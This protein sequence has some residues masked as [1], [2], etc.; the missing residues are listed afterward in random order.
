MPGCSSSS[1]SGR[2]DC[3]ASGQASVP[4]ALRRNLLI[5]LAGCVALA[6]LTSWVNAGSYGVRL[7]TMAAI[8][9]LLALGYQ[10]VF[11][12]LGAFSL[13]QG[14]FF[15][16]G[17][18]ATALLATRLGLDAAIT[19]PLS[20]AIAVG[21]A[22]I[23]A[24]PVLRLESHYFALATLGLA[25]LA[26]LVAVNAESL[27]GGGNGLPGVPGLALLGWDVPRG[28][29][30]MTA[31]WMLVALAAAI[32]WRGTSGRSRHVLM[33]VRDDPIAAESL[34]IDIG[35]LRFAAF[36]FA[37]GCAG[38]AGALQAHLLGIV[39]P[40]VLEFP[41]MVACLS[42][43][44][45]GGRGSIAGAV[46][47]A[48][49]LVH[50]PELLRGVGPW[51]LAV[52]GAALLAM[53]VFAPEG[54]VGLL[55]RP[56]KPGL[57]ESAE[58]ETPLPARGED[59][60]AKPSGTILRLRGVRKKFGGVAALA[61]IDLEIRAGELVGIIGPN[62]SGKTTLVNVIAGLYRPDGGRVEFRGKAIQDEPAWR[63]ARAGIGRGFQA[64]RLLDHLTVEDNVAI[65]AIAAG[66]GRPIAAARLVRRLGL[67]SV[68]RS[69]LGMLPGGARR[70][71][72]IARAMMGRPSL[73]LL[74]EPAAG[75]TPAEQEELRA[76]LAAL[77][78][79]SVAILVIEHSVAFLSRLVP[80]MVCMVE[81][82]IVADGTPPDVT[83]DPQV[84]AAY[85]GK[86]P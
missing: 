3:S 37:A 78:R 50:L 63:I 32:A 15:G 67:G 30:L 42:M 17:A 18:Y 5:A 20:A 6:A 45:I 22:A 36:L 80:R 86:K 76:I 69:R 85:L 82:K 59:A 57:R 64:P 47:G 62:G 66:P 46:L 79:D 43:V 29:P 28:W 65:A 73:L 71:V 70:R 48:V 23:V 27:T 51:Y 25:Q 9:A 68:A 56:M 7:A 38:I 35:R 34:G 33:L 39:S 44:V 61:G 53:I 10:L 40:E 13:A 24:A 74:D 58:D 60:T 19:L 54:I 75:L 41:V 84:V 12:Q 16:I 72:E 83:A 81:G 14:A 26:L 11:G 21:V 1:S 55:E 2:A 49:L 52:Y 8:Y 4:D 77:N 31:C